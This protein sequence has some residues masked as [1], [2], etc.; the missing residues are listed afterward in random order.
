MF[1]LHPNDLFRSQYTGAGGAALIMPHLS[2]QHLF[3]LPNF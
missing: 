3:L 2:P 1:E